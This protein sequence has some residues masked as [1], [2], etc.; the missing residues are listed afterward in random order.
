MCVFILYVIIYRYTIDILY[1]L[2]ITSLT[3]LYR[4]F[5]NQIWDATFLKIFD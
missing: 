5:G 1:M 4:I 3:G 2:R